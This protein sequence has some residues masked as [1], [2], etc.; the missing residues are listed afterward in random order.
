MGSGSGAGGCESSGDKSEGRGGP[1]APA[2]G[3]EGTASGVWE[4]ADKAVTCTVCSYLSALCLVLFLFLSVSPVSC[5]VF[6]LFKEGCVLSR[7]SRVRLY[8]PLWTAAHQ[9]PLSLG[10]FRQKYWSW[11]SSPS[12]G[13]LPDP[14]IEPLSPTS[15]FFLYS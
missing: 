4:T 13:D 10:F 15:S 5:P 8:A 14:G 2:G 1:G 9:A 7:F 3:P 11:W 6:V 12:P